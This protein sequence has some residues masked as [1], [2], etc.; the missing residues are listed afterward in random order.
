[1]PYKANPTTINKKSILTFHGQVVHPDLQETDVTSMF[2]PNH[3]VAQ[4]T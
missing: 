1:M 2:S 3:R 4:N